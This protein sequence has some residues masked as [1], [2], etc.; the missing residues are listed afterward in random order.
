MCERLVFR[1]ADS[2]LDGVY[3]HPETRRCLEP[4]SQGRPHLLRLTLFHCRYRCIVG[5][6]QGLCRPARKTW[7]TTFSLSH[8]G[9]EELAQQL[10]R[11]M[12]AF[13]K[14]LVAD[15][16][17]PADLK[18]M[19]KTIAAENRIMMLVNN[20]RASK[21]AP[22][23]KVLLAEVDRQMDVNAGA[24]THLSLAALPCFKERD[25]GTINIG[26]VLS[27]YARSSPRHTAE[28]RAT[29]SLH[30]ACSRKLDAT[31]LS[32]LCCRQ[33]RRRRLGRG[34]GMK[35]LDPATIMTAED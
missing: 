18:N 20:T 27:F 22:S 12:R 6:R 34:V 4:A 21:F 1:I 16:G 25:R 17:N 28:R 31:S 9:L 10:R 29:C 7:G 23:V 15:L 35:G 11:D 3:G 26:S 13:V 2:R 30:S 32:S 5:S 33:R 24:P 19:T 14:T 8:V